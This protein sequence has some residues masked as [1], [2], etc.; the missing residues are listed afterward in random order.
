MSSAAQCNN[1]DSVT[2]LV[3]FIHDVRIPSG[4]V[5]NADAIVALC[6]GDR[7]FAQFALE[8][9]KV[10]SVLSVQRFQRVTKRSLVVG[11]RIEEKN[12]SLRHS[13]F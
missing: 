10:E 3:Y 13:S 4:T 1:L 6:F 7:F 8:K 12:L 11:F 9:G 5:D 2:Q